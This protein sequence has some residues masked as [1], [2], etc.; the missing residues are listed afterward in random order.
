MTAPLSPRKSGHPTSISFDRTSER[1]LQ[2]SE[3]PI[4]IA[5]T[6][7]KPHPNELKVEPVRADHVIN[8]AEV[9]KLEGMLTGIS[10]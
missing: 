3:V 5:R 10:A 7:M 4:E 6:S 1:V 8:I 2:H 9:S